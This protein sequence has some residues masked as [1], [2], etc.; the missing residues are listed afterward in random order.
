MSEYSLDSYR[1]EITR[2][3]SEH[4]GDAGKLALL[5]ALDA[6]GNDLEASL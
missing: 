5:D 6:W 1:A 4:A 2:L 3:R